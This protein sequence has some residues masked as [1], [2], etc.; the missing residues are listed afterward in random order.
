MTTLQVPLDDR[1]KAFVDSQAAVEGH[2]TATDYVLALLREAEKRKAWKQV[3]E[4][5]LAGLDS[6]AEEMTAADWEALRQ[7]I[8][9]PTERTTP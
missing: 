1:Q 6:P 3:E 9:T 2:P 8:P 4:L 7:Q 5:V